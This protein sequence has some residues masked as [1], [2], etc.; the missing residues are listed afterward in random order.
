MRFRAVFFD[1]GE[2][3]VHPSPSFAELFATI[4]TREGHPRDAVDIAE[5]LTTVSSAFHRAAR[6]HDLWTTT[7]ERSRRFWSA[8]YD[9]FLEVLGIPDGTGLTDT[10][11]REFTDLGNYAAF[12]DVPPALERL[13]DDGIPMGI[14]SNFEPWLED[15][16]HRLELTPFF[17]VRVISG[18]EGLEKPDPAIFRLALDR[19]GIAPAEAVYV[20]D[21]P[22]FDVAPTA[23]LGMF[24]VLIDR[25]GRHA[26]F[27]GPGVRITSM[28]ELSSVLE[29]A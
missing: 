17:A 21:I 22:D 12:T 29:A 20:G 15:L 16:L 10:L 3:L 11:Y 4:V 27:D 7:P 5:G 9:R 24:P 2:T 6:E 25:R 13:R 8:V 1:A 26:G 19:A 23:A 14:V 18:I 28:D